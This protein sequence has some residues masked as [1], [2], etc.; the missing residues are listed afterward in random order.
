M[1]LMMR[2]F[3]LKKAVAGF[4]LVFDAHP[5]LWKE[6]TTILCCNYS[7]LCQLQLGILP[8]RDEINRFSNKG[9]M[10]REDRM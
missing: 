9:P 2:H 8:I 3:G 4:L 5:S 6:V 7:L 10:A 1:D